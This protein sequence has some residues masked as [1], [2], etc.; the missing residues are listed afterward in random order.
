MNYEPSSPL[1][2]RLPPGLHVFFTPRQTG[3]EPNVCDALRQLFSPDLKCHSVHQS[4]SSPPILSGR[5]SSA[6]TYQYY[7]PLPSILHFQTWLA[8]EFCPG[9]FAGRCP[10]EAAS[11]AYASYV[12]IDFDAISHAVTATA[13]WRAGIAPKAGVDHLRAEKV[14]DGDRLE[15]GV[16]MPEKP[17]DDEPESLKLG[18]WLAVAGEDDHASKYRYAKPINPRADDLSEPTVFSFPS[19]HHPLP[20]A[21]PLTFTSS[22]N[23]PT[24]LHPEIVLSF[25]SQHLKPPKDEPSCALH[26]YLTLPSALFLDQYQLEDPALLAANKL[27]AIRSLSGEQDLE[28][29]DWVVT[30]WGSAALIEL[31]SP[32]TKTANTWNVTI[33]THLRYL[34]S[35][36]T[37]NGSAI[38][39]VD[40]HLPVPIV[41]WACKAEEGLKMSVN[42]FDRVNLGYD[43]LF[44]PKTMFYHVPAA[45]P[46]DA[47]ASPFL[48]LEL[49]VPVMERRWGGIV[50]AGTL[51]TVVVGFLMVAVGL[52]RGLGGETNRRKGSKGA[53]KA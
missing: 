26:T 18:G 49:K 21:N 1:V 2:S 10:N 50:Q 31:A 43:G 7:Q 34:R 6:A 5:F 9:E 22:F 12:D 52:F 3:P 36:E 45:S 20:R 44:G 32:P 41:F 48:E 17:G 25:P 4:F 14:K 35:P 53:K 42:P 24:G 27:I 29:P 39:H 15:V 11:L 16:L 30:Q 46:T 13:V 47:D 8:K 33:P 38:H 51:V 40:L 28:A 23:Q 37:E 19:R